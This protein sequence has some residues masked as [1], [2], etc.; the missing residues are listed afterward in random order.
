MS[1]LWQYLMETLRR[2]GDFS[3]LES[4]FIKTWKRP[5]CYALYTVCL[6][7]LAANLLG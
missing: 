2:F 7:L 4:A 6:W 1:K 3:L 5:R